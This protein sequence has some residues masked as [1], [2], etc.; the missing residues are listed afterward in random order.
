VFPFHAGGWAQL[1]QLLGL[2]RGSHTLLAAQKPPLSTLHLLLRLLQAVAV[3]AG[4]AGV[5]LD[6]MR[7]AFVEAVSQGSLG[8]LDSQQ[9][10]VEDA[11]VSMLAEMMEVRPHAVLVQVSCCV[12]FQSPAVGVGKLWD[13]Q[14]SLTQL[15]I[16]VQAGQGG[17][18]AGLHEGC[19]CGGGCAGVPWCAVLA[20]AAADGGR[21][22]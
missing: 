4:P 22:R 2:M 19:F 14:E 17:G 3:S 21:G 13:V 12:C 8:V 15:N 10:M 5:Q 16:G 11:D 7:D 9:Q 6:C 1:G 20:A 18:V